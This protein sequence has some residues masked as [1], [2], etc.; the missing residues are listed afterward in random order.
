MRSFVKKVAVV[1]G[2]TVG[3]GIALDFVLGGK[4]VVV[5]NRTPESAQ[6]SLDRMSRS[7]LRLV[8]FGIVDALDLAAAMRRVS[9]TAEIADAVAAADYVVEAVPEDPRVKRSVLAEI[10]RHTDPDVVIAST[11]TAI[12]VADLALDCANPKRVLTARYTLPAHLIPVVDVVAAEETAPSAVEV[13]LHVLT[14]LGKRPVLLN[15]DAP[16]GIGPRLLSA[17][18]SEAFR[19]VDEGVADPVTIDEVVTGGIGRRLGAVGVFD[20]IDVAGLDT[21]ASVFERQGRPVPRALAEKIDAGALGRKVGRGFYRWEPADVEEFDK[22]EAR[23]LTGHMLRDRRAAGTSAPTAVVRVEPGVLDEFLGRAQAEYTAA[24]PQ[25]PPRCFAV[26]LGAV[27]DGLIH[28]I[29][30]RFARTVRNDDGNAAAVWQNAIVPCFG[31]AYAN[32]RRGFWVHPNDLLRI[33]READADGLD[34]LGSIH[35]HP[36]WHRTGPPAE[37]GMRISERPTPMDRFLIANTG[38]PLNMICYLEQTRYGL[39]STVAAW[40]PPS[41]A[42]PAGGCTRLTIQHAIA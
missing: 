20:R 28:V 30:T 29:D 37:R 12:R 21:V 16:G 24:T 31:A 9:T 10:D 13:V 42:D 36:D 4:E 33:S 8:E 7:G 2:G 23:H 19:L 38:W 6:R 34:V 22:R 32:D 17:M 25:N 18:M 40:G 26:L 35:L 3:V 1:G 39:G 15:R 41:V 27:S 11:T 5:C 14:E